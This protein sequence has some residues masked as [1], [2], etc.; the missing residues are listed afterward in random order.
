MWRNWEFL[1]SKRRRKSAKMS[2]PLK[3]SRSR[4]VEM[5]GKSSDLNYKR[6][7]NVVCKMREVLKLDVK[8]HLVGT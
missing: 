7:R 2:K 3:F 5:Y 6:R 1:E 4:L 8:G